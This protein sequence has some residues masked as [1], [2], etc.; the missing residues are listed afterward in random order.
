MAGASSDALTSALLGR[1]ALLMEMRQA[2]NA[3]RAAREVA[4]D[5][6]ADR[7]HHG[8]PGATA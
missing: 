7:M 6:F 4:R 5:P 3:C 1:P 8:P 2:G